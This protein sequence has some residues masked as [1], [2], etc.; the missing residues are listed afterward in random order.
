VLFS[1]SHYCSYSNNEIPLLDFITGKG[2]AL[3]RVEDENVS[4]MERKWKTTLQ[5]YNYTNTDELDLLLAESVKAGYFV[6]DEFRDKASAQNQQIIASKSEGALSKAWKLYHD[7][8][9]DNGKEVING[10]YESFK[11]NCKNI[12]VLNLASTVSLL[13]KLGEDD[14]ASQIIEIYI[15]NRKD[16][17]ELFDM[18]DNNTF[19][20]IKDNELINRFNDLYNQSVK[21][22]TAKQVLKRI[23]L[24]SGWGQKDEV[25]LANTSV[26]E[27]YDLFKSIEGRQLQSFVTKCLKFGQSGNASDQHKKITNLATDALLKIASE[28][29]I[30][31]FRVQKYGVKIDDL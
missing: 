7:T 21:T 16:E 14:K 20:D 18:E 11:R 27:Y 29:Q 6:E 23:A 13:R 26:D 12:T 19:G 1:W 10:L 3:T 31:K 22:E 24:E 28:S 8:F 15:E 30:N 9:N 17:I 25:V 2:Y 5:S 4:E